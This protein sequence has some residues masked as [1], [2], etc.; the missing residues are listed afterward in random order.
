LQSNLQNEGAKQAEKKG[1]TRK[2][3]LNGRDIIDKLRLK[4]QY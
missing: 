2:L 4:F 1:F 3:K